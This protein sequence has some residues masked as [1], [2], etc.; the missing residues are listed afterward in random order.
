M[1]EALWR[2]ISRQSWFLARRL[3]VAGLELQW[4]GTGRTIRARRA[5]PAA[6]LAGP[7]GEL[8]LYLFGRKDAAQVQVTGPPAAVEAVRHTRFGM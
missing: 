5:E 1:D 8:L 7:P 4:M 2:N 3:H 6:C